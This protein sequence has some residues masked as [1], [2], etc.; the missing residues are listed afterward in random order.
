MKEKSNKQKVC[1]TI[2]TWA[3]E[4]NGIYNYKSKDS[5]INEV[6]A[7][8]EESCYIIREKNRIIKY[9]QN[10]EYNDEKEG[11]ILFYLRKSLKNDQM[12]EIV[13]PV[14][15]IIEKNEYNINDLNRRPWLIVNSKNGSYNKEEEYNLNENDIIKLGRRKFEI[16]KKNVHKYESNNTKTLENQNGY[17]ISKINNKR[18]AIFNIDIK[19]NQYRY[20]PTKSENKNELNNEHSNSNSTDEIEEEEANKNK[21]SDIEGR[22]NELCRICFDCKSTR[23]NPKIRLCSCRDFIH[24][25]CLKSYL[26]TKT[27]IHENEN[28]T[29][30]TY[31]CNKFNCD[32]CCKPYPL[33]FRIPEF[34]R[35][36]EL[37]DLTVPL[38]FDYIILESLDYIK[39]RYNL[40]TVHI[41]YLNED[42]IKI[43]RNDENDII[44]TDISV[45][46]RHA[47]LKFHKD[48]GKLNLINISEKFGTLILIK[49]NIKMKE[50][51]IHFQVGKSYIKAQLKDEDDSSKL[52]TNNLKK[53]RADT[54]N[55]DD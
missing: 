31:I 5:E 27:E 44:D 17:N 54:D 14:K 6:I 1:L 35:T 30:K 16:I 13:N 36:Y 42:E 21:D 26:N 47:M 9:E 39:E 33:R 40:K 8:L 38:E 48:T 37:I 10:Y 22:E 20:I 29:V 19:K 46:R 3:S 7:S 23:E 32:V 34:D 24:F 45:S 2:K 52:N 51:D 25:E 55:S 12:F 18:G 49:G 15:K 43:G 41:V 50:N 11:Q 28:L 4:S 53:N